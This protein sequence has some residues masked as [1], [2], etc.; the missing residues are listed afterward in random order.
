MTRDN[1]D[2]DEPDKPLRLEE[3]DNSEDRVW[4]SMSA[5]FNGKGTYNYNTGTLL[6]AYLWTRLTKT[7]VLVSVAFEVENTN[8]TDLEEFTRKLKKLGTTV[9]LVPVNKNDM[10]DCI[11]QALWLRN[12]GYQHPA[13]GEEDLIMI[14]EGDVFISSDRV[15]EPL[16]NRNYRVWLYW[17]EPALYGQTFAMSFTTLRKKDWRIILGNTSSC[18]Q[19]LEKFEYAVAVRTLAGGRGQKHWESDQNIV[20]AQLLRLGL[21]TLPVSHRLTNLFHLK[22][23]FLQNNTQRETSVSLG[24]WDGATCFKGQGWGECRSENFGNHYYSGMGGCPWWHHWFPEERLREIAEPRGEDWIYQWL[25]Q[26]HL[27]P[28]HRVLFKL[29]DPSKP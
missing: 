27:K 3:E 12:L 29:K 5:C 1:I 14:S 11:S 9:I 7:K 10:C 28:F 26:S 20:S 21:C 24:G 25:N 4:I 18:Q 16:N 19:A 13:I 2:L 8:Q 15:M 23:F 6:S 22:E 17:I